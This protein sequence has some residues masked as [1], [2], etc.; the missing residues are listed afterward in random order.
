[1]ATNKD[2]LEKLE[3]EMQELKDGMQKLSSDSQSNFKESQSNLK[4]IRE[5][6]SKSFEQGESSADK[7]KGPFQMHG[8]HSSG[9]WGGSKGS[10][11]FTKLEF[12]RYS[13]DDPTV[14]LN[15][16]VQYFDYKQ[17]PEEQK[18]S[19]AAFHLESE[20]NQWW[21]WLQKLYTEERLPITWEAFERELLVRFGPT[22]VEDYDE[23]L[24]KI[25]QMGTLREYQQEFERLANRVEGWRQKALVGAFLGGL[26][27][28]IVS[29]IRMFKPKTLRDAIELARMRD[30][31]LSKSRK[32]TRNDGPKS[33]ATNYF[34]KSTGHVTIATGQA[35][36][37]G[38]TPAARTYSSGGAKRLSWEEMQKRREKGL[39]FSCNEK[40]TPGH[41]CQKPQ[42][43]LLEA[44]SMEGGLDD[45]GDPIVEV[46]EE[47]TSAGEEEPLISLHA[48]AGCNGPK[49]MR[50]KAVI[51]KRTL[52]IL[53][54]SGSTHN[55]V[56]QKIA[57]SLQ[58]AVKPVE[59]FVVKVANGE[60]LRCRERY[61]NVLI[62]IQGFQFST[63]LYSLPLHG[64]DAVLG[65]QWLEN[66]GPVLCDWKKMTMNFQWND[67]PIKLA[68]QAVVPTHEILIQ[69]LDREMQGGGELFAIVSLA[70]P[71]T[72]AT[73]L[74]PEIQDL[75][76]EFHHVLEEAQGIPPSRIFD[77]IIP[78]KEDTAPVNVRPY[79]YA[80]FQKNEIE[81][82]VQEMLTTGL[83]RPSTS[84]FSSP[85]LLVKK[86]D[87][88]WRFCTDYRALNAVT[89]KDR[90]PI[91]TVD[92]MLDELHGAVYFT[93]LDLRAGY[94]QIRVHSEDIYK[95]AFRTHSGHYEYVV[96]P[97][98]LCNAPSTFQAA[99]NEVFRPYLRKFLLVF[100]DDILI[101]S[102][103]WD[104]HVVHLR[105]IFEI[106]SAQ[107]FYVKPSKC[108]FGAH[109]V[110]YLGHIISHEGV[111]VDNRKIDAMQSWP[112]PKTITELRGFLGLT[113]YYRKFV[114]NYGPIAA[115]LTELLKKGNFG[116]NPKANAAFE[117]LKTAMVTTPVLALPDFS[118]K[119]IVETDAS[120]YGIGAILSQRG[121]PIAYLSKALGPTKR[122]WSIYSKEMLAIME[123]IRA[124]R[125]Y[126]LGSKFQIQTDQKSL[127]FLLEQRIVTPEQQKWVSK[128]VGFD[129]EI[130]Y[131]PGRANVAADAMS[132]MP[133]SP[134]LLSITAP[135]ID[136]ISGPHL[137][138]WEDL[139]QL[140]MVDPYLLGLHK[141]L[142]AHPELMPHYKVR[143]G[144]IFFKGRLVIPPT[145]PL[146][147][148]ILHEFHSS[149]LAGHSGILRT[150]KR[151]AQ[152]FFWEAMKTDVQHFV[153]ECDVCQRNKSEARSPAG[154][155]QPLPIP[156]QVWEDI[157]LDFIDGLPLSKGKNSI[158]VVVDRLTKYGHF[159]ALS[160]PYSAKKIA[161]I[162]VSGVMKLHGVPRSI[163]SDRDSI[164]LSSF[165]KEFFQIQGTKLKMSSAYHP[166][167][168][169]QTEVVNRCLEQYLRC[170]TSQHPKQWE[171]FLAWAEYWYN[172]SFH[173]SINTTPFQALYGR[174]PPR[175]VNYLVGTSPVSEV[176]H[177]LQDRDELLRE[178][179]LHLHNSNNRMKQYADAKRR[180]VHFQVNDWVY[181]KLQ[182][183]RQHSV[184]HRAHQKLANK[185]FGPF[186]VLA[187]VGPVAYRLALPEESKVHNVFHVSLLKKKLGDIS[188]ISTTLPPFSEDTG[189]II[190][191]LHILDYRWV[192]KGS[193]FFTEALIQWK[194]LAPEDA[195]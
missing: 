55:F 175:L 30:E 18:V 118:E 177:N 81:R 169:G 75:L 105:K 155:L 152:N 153:S 76:E 189:P 129:Y 136:G 61:E 168:D 179:K 47:Q 88:S 13:G 193:K 44:F 154:L 143:E 157:S 72:E 149:K 186:K 181:L 84:P 40:F 113:G 52:V 92:D 49:T 41:R 23:A 71:K 82:Q 106:L 162:F 126:L 39:C 42:A 185:Y 57:H 48:I 137:S 86:K 107:Q 25:Q 24:T 53:I 138:L 3:S 171:S 164:F 190:E 43:F 133:H 108:T 79:R 94:H 27:Q 187:E 188:N 78:L 80:H 194:H 5:L 183:Y 17:T 67:Q 66:L 161:E 128:L 34:Q 142:E 93:K 65:I 59:E 140:N 68:A 32:A 103:H 51:G 167:S 170:F 45:V 166:Q 125:T 12:P 120:D 131:R 134:L 115:P 62:T 165:W 70:K 150:L 63:T 124:W 22:E 73:S 6:L 87:G 116:W 192:K 19:L 4:E 180:E 28:D 69:A 114:R 144:L 58:L 163:V 145:S 9:H 117:T 109:E 123:A 90:F 132:R 172:T 8:N 77:H 141:K 56:D 33:Q 83:I 146:K 139:R 130:V 85:I 29:A 174:A 148:E 135:A 159:F 147:N 156:T 101:Y 37:T 111:R 14:W 15:R 195:T 100:F 89:I 46:A 64:L 119:F 11:N 191:P 95:T 173:Q 121:R 102:K 96:M 54:D 36:S 16:V 151:L 7:E 158:L 127:K 176:D 122:A 91:P 112:Q 50:I 74:P 97:F 2:R 38:T 104:E 184:F 1:M 182:P 160:H 178:L 99:M 110:D 26:K 10:N 31:N 21:Q 60:R 20:A 98:G 35:A